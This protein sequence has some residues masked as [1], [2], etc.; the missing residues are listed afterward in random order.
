MS[1]R[2]E[3]GKGREVL[4][5][6]ISADDKEALAAAFDRLSPESRYRRFFAPLE[7]LSAQD[8]AYLT[9]VDHH[10]HEALVALDPEDDGIVGVARYVRSD[11][12]AEAEVAVV[13]SDPWQGNG[14]GSA[15]LERLVERARGEGIDH[16]VALVMSDN[17][18]ALELFRR[19]APEGS[20]IRRSA[21]GHSEM[22]IE[23]PEPGGLDESRL[24]RVLAAVAAEMLSVNPWSVLR[25]AI[26]RRP[27]EEM[28][29]PER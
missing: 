13:V 10:D 12:E 25:R 11:Q 19:I 24:G 22:L 29:L 21:S 6:P 18:E 8:L 15:L 9:D 7:R 1:E 28:K 5:R 26:R 3:V 4:V 20:W 23:L 17:E 27:T 2:V 14:V 16:F